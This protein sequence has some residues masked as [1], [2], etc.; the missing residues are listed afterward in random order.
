MKVYHAAVD[1]SVGECIRPIPT[2]V[3][4]VDIWKHHLIYQGELFRGSS[5]A[6]FILRDG[7][8]VGFSTELPW[9]IEEDLKIDLEEIV[10]NVDEPTGKIKIFGCSQAVLIQKCEGLVQALR[11]FGVI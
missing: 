11:E 6:P 9:G 1:I 4:M 5:G 3:M 10:E 7:R 8:V 2:W